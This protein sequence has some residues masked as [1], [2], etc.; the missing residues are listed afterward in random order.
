MLV[1]IH[2]AL[3]LLE[4]IS[5]MKRM[6]LLVQLLLIGMNLSSSMCVCAGCR[7]V[8]RLR[9][10]LFRDYNSEENNAINIL[11]VNPYRGL[12]QNLSANGRQLVKKGFCIISM[13]KCSQEKRK[14]HKYNSMVTNTGITQI[15]VRL[16]QESQQWCCGFYAWKAGKDLTGTDWR[17]CD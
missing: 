6:R 8:C 2:I 11:M 12:W 14:E 17:S 1:H 13:I 7:C 10:F 3:T 9:S 5:C 16:R 4:Y 15:L